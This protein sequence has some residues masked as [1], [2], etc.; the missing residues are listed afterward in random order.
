MHLAYIDESG[1]PGPEGSLT[2]VLACIL[3]RDS[4]WLETLDSLISFRRF[5]KSCFG[6]PVRAEL[7]AND[8]VQRRG[9]FRSLPVGLDGRRDIYRQ[10]MR[11]HQKLDTKVFAIVIEKARARARG[12]DPRV[13]CWEFLFQRLERFSSGEQSHLIAVHDEG[14]TRLV[15]T[16]ARMARRVGGAGSH[17]G[18]GRINRPARL[19]IED[20]VPRRSNDS[21][22]I[23]IAD[24]CAYAAYRH[25]HPAA[26]GVPAATITPASL[27]LELGNAA[28]TEVNQVKG[29][30]LAIVH[31]P[32]S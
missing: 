24:L 28:R 5:L 1:D 20:P 16:L 19:L 15:R 30:P 2:Y 26:P 8:L 4:A 32:T 22:F 17:F 27:W 11:L 12:H 7:K 21:Y 3:V 29:G 14:E 13:L 31:W 18:T 10:A 25:I 6:L 9:P 23:Q